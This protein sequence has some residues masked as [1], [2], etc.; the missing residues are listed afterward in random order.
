[1]SENKSMTFTEL[2]EYIDLVATN[3]QNLIQQIGQSDSTTLA[4]PESKK[5]VMSM[6]M[7]A[8]NALIMEKIIE[9]LKEKRSNIL[10]T[11]DVPKPPL[12]KGGRY[13]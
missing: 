1:M 5:G 12:Q 7:N 6:T 2:E 8:C 13:A 4:S 3:T 10:V 9:F 11:K